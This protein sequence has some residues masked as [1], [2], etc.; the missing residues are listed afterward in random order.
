MFLE[1]SRWRKFPE[2]MA[3]HIFS[4]ED[5]IKNFPIMNQERVSDE[6]RRNCRPTRPSFD[7]LFG[8]TCIHLIDLLYQVKLDEWS[9]FQRSSHKYYLAFFALRRSTMN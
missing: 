1:D 7:R 3:Y 2:F 9:L 6:I 8:A 4:H 5:G